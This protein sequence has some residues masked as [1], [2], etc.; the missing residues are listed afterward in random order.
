MQRTFSTPEPVSMYVELRSG[1][2]AITTAETD[3]TVS[4]HRAPA[5]SDRW[6]GRWP[7]RAPRC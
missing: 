2:L 7:R 3:E 1:D 5:R 4:T 6:W